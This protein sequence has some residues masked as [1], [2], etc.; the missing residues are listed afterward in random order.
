MVPQVAFE[1]RC[2]QAYSSA[3]RHYGDLGLVPEVFATRVAE[4]AKRHLGPAPPEVA[5]LGFVGHLRMRDLYLAT[6]CALPSDS[7]LG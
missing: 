3:Y 7:A 2:Q 5:V 6:S 4:I 1:A